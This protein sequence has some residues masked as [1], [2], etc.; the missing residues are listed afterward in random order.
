M[1]SG[2]DL[3]LDSDGS[4]MINMALGL[5]APISFLSSTQLAEECFGGRSNPKG[6]GSDRTCSPQ[7]MKNSVKL[8]PFSLAE[9]HFLIKTERH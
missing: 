7:K 5:L 3:I 1:V 4:E 2:Q 9:F 8:S 6:L